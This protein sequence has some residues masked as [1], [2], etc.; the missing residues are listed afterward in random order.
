[1]LV[2]DLFWAVGVELQDHKPQFTRWTA[3]EVMQAYNEAR[4]V[5]ARL[6]PP[7]RARIEAI[8]LKPGSLQ[9]IAALA[10]A[11]VKP[12]P[13]AALEGLQFMEL[14][15]NLGGD[16]ITPGPSI[17]VTSRELL[18]AYD[19][20]WHTRTGT[21]IRSYTHDPRFPNRFMVEPAVPAT[22][23]VW[24][25]CAYMAMP[26]MLDLPTLDDGEAWALDGDEDDQVDLPTEFHMDIRFYMVARLSMKNSKWADPS[27]ASAFT[28]F[29]T[30]SMNTKV[31]T[32][33]GTNPNLRRLPMA[34]EPLTAAQ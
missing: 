3:R 30:A 19:P 31:S 14:L 11:D 18:D 23:N 29:F 13:G 7:A 27:K 33:T 21:V 10:Q 26:P 25:R 17:T 12:D 6:M 5:I 15:D 34:T 32:L 1:M 20:L 4:I 8:R 28:E 24:A 9:S 16:G 22:G 2:R